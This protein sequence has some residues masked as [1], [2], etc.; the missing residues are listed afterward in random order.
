M[1]VQRIHKRLGPVRVRR[2][3]QP[4]L[5][6]TVHSAFVWEKCQPVSRKQL[7]KPR[8]LDLGDMNPPLMNHPIVWSGHSMATRSHACRQ[9][10]GLQ[11]GRN[12]DHQVQ[13]RHQTRC[14][15]AIL[16]RRRRRSHKKQQC[17]ISC[18]TESDKA[19]HV[20]TKLHYTTSEFHKYVRNSHL[21]K[22]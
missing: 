4:L 10:L 6:L 12:A 1:Y 5:L 17:T 7:I 18:N 14:L 3:K 15:M 16:E 11:S 21:M 13:Q 19:M 9:S 22:I 20:N 8:A 2:C